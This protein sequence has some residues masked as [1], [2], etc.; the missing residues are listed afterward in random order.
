MAEHT[1]RCTPRQERENRGL[2]T[3]GRR[4]RCD[5][6]RGRLGR[7]GQHADGS[8]RAIDAQTMANSVSGGNLPSDITGKY[9]LGVYPRDQ[10]AMSNHVEL[11]AK[12]PPVK[13]GTD[14]N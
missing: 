11:S 2:R 13:E 10:P 1:R 6:E 8:G 5:I 12:K 7:D 9:S 3:P 14:P 4:S